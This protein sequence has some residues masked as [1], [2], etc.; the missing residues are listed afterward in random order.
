MS[1]LRLPHVHKQAQNWTILLSHFENLYNRSTESQFVELK[2]PRP[3]VEASYT[4]ALDNYRRSL[5][6]GVKQADKPLLA[7]QNWLDALGTM[8]LAYEHLNLILTQAE[9]GRN[10]VLSQ[11]QAR[12]LFDTTSL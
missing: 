8:S 9:E 6:P 10:I 2:Y 5:I 3:D 4:P 12:G 1:S 7:G 11:D